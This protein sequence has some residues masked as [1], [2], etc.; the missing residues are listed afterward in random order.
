MECRISIQDCG[1]W[2]YLKMLMCR[3][4]RQRKVK[5]KRKWKNDIETG[6]TWVY[7]DIWGLQHPTDL[8][9]KTTEIRTY[10]IRCLGLRAVGLSGL[11]NQNP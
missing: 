11:L 3:G 1:I 5:R 6:I 10:Q 4:F 7:E 8:E 2:G 9:A